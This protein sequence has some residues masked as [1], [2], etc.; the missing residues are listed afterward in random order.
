V[1]LVGGFA[2]SPYLHNALENWCWQNGDIILIRPEH[3]QV[4]PLRIVR[5]V[6]ILLS[7]SAVVRGA[8]LRGLEGIAPRMKRVR[9]HYGFIMGLPFREGIDPEE[10]AYYRQLSNEKLCDGRVKWLISK[11]S[12]PKSAL[13]MSSAAS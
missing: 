12:Y 6:L 11:V 1:V 9:R 8:A 13:S 10:K 7:Q 5:I 2:E 3:S 4:L